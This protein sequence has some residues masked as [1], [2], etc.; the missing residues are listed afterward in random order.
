MEVHLHWIPEV[1]LQD[2]NM[3]QILDHNSQNVAYTFTKCKI[4]NDIK[5]WK[6]N[7]FQVLQQYDDILLL[8]HRS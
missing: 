8:W 4:T 3:Q 6:F 5:I 2:K 1:N 7:T